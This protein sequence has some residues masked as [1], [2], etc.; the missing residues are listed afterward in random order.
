VIDPA[1]GLTK[2]ELARY[3][4]EV[5]P[6]LLPYA[7]KRPLALVRCPDGAARQCFF[8]KHHMPGIGP[9]VRRGRAGKHEVL[10]VDN[11]AGLVELAQFNVIELHGW[12]ATID[13]P[14][15][16]DWFVLDLDP[17]TGIPFSRVVEAAREVRSALKRIGLR[18][19][20][21][22]TGGKGLHVCVPLEPRADWDE[23]KAFTH[24]IARS[25]EAQHPERY[26]STLSKAKRVGKIFIDYLRNGEGA[27]AVL[28]YSARA[29]P[30]ATVAM[31]VDWAQIGK[32]DP[33]DFSVRTAI[34]WLKKR[35]RDPWQEFLSS[36]QRLP[37]L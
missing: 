2:L 3:H 29:R 25:L 20:V 23:V 35:R 13:H 24:A 32:L 17:D 15:R 36:P 16:P 10:Y 28:P 22:T 30:G 8:Q 9:D 11:A 34:A 37:A 27:T 26:V 19:W 6:W 5:A 1:S 14:E 31:P 12:G 33:K 7:R 21:K 4:A 18:S